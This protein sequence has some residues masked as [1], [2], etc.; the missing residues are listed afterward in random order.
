MLGQLEVTGFSDYLHP[1]GE[2]LLLGIGYETDPDTSRTL[3]VKLTMFDISNPTE[4]TV[5]DSVVLDGDY[6]ALQRITSVRLW[7]WIRISLDSR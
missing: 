5:V 1:Y 4:L 3:G 2:N 6:C 7:M